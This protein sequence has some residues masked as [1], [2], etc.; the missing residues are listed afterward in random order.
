MPDYLPFIVFAVFVPIV[1]FITTYNR[2]IKYKNLMEEGWSI[3]D[4]MLKRRANLIPKLIATVQGYS[5]HEADV[6]ASVTEQRLDSDS[7][8]AINRHENEV[9]TS[10]GGLL[11]VAEAYPN[12]KASAN[13]LELQKALSEVEDDLAT[14]RNKYNQRVRQMNI[15]VQQF[16]SNL[17]AKIFHFTREDY[18]TLKLATEREVPETPWS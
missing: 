6:L 11:A 8:D 7:H 18:F 15:L 14:A 10:L 4:V 1:W 2:F 3:I 12:L 17:I 16:P 5:K 9:S 13:F